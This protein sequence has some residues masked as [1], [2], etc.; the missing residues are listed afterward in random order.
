LA[1]NGHG[2]YAYTFAGVGVGTGL[3]FQSDWTDGGAA[4]PQTPTIPGDQT[5]NGDGVYWTP[6]LQLSVGQGF[7][8]LN[9]NGAEAWNQTITNIP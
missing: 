8:I 9:P 4:P 6:D 3:G 5:D 2:Y 1:Y 7:F